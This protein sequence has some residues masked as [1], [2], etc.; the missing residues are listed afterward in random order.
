M[1]KHILAATDGSD[2]SVRAVQMAGELAAALGAKLT[3]VHVVMHSDPPAGLERM[4]EIEHLVGTVTGEAPKRTPA[5]LRTLLQDTD[6]AAQRS[7]TMARLGEE[8]ANRAEIQAR[9]A[10]VKDVAT[11]VVRGDYAERIL[12]AADDVHA[13]LIVMGRRG[14]GTL[15]RLLQGSVSQKVVAHADCAVL[16]VA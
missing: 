11:E 6:T 5:D 3:I 10:G 16:T 12:Q 2:T 8:I 14:L 9:D 13:D 1:V 15:S 7:V 4:A